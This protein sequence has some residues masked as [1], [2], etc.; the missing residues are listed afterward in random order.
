MAGQMWSLI[1]SH[2]EGIAT[3]KELRPI[4]ADGGLCRRFQLGA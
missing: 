4:T 3:L 1:T 2:R